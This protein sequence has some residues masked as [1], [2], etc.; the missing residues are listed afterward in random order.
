[1][2]V[3]IL[4]ALIDLIL[5]VVRFLICAFIEKKYATINVYD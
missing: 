4:E 5:Y 1:M 3:H 2:A